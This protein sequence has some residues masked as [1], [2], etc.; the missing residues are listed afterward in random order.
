MSR[1]RGRRAAVEKRGSSSEKA[2]LF[3]ATGGLGSWSPR[4]THFWV[5]QSVPETRQRALCR[6]PAGPWAL[7]VL[8]PGRPGRPR[9]T[10]SAN[11]ENGRSDRPPSWPRRG[12]RPRSAR[13]HA[14]PGV[15]DACHGG[16]KAL[17]RG[18]A[19]DSAAPGRTFPVVPTSDTRV[20]GWESAVQAAGAWPLRPRLWAHVTVLPG[21]KGRASP[22][23]L[24]DAA[25]GAPGVAFV[26]GCPAWKEPLPPRSPGRSAQPLPRL[27]AWTRDPAPPP[28]ERTPHVAD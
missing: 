16:Q 26:T 24:T 27:R 8:P 4:S 5:P 22:A 28:E 19:F 17:C 10:V 21:T 18:G 7:V 20:R 23:S 25:P 11:A 14:L 6:R 9:G 15:P 13:G 1:G 12:P 2:L 3:G